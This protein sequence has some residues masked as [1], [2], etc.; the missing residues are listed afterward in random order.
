MQMGTFNKP[1]DDYRELC[2]LVAVYL[3]GSVVRR[4]IDGTLTEIEFKMGHPG[5]FHDS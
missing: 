4:R 1:R 5:A 2:E 3:G